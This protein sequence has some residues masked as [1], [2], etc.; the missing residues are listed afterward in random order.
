MGSEVE[1]KPNKEDVQSYDF[2]YTVS[3][4]VGEYEVT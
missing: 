4:E 1:F 3:G 2:E